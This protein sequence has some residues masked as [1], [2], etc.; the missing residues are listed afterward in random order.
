MRRQ[1][2]LIERFFRRSPRA[3][4]SAK[5]A[6]WMQPT[7]VREADGSETPLPRFE[8]HLLCAEDGMFPEDC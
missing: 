2:N 3:R 7:T 6:S 1:R 4:S 5:P 8:R